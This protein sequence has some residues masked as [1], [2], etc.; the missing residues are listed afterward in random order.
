MDD[1]IQYGKKKLSQYENGGLKEVISGK[2]NILRL[3]VIGT[4]RHCRSN[5]LPNLPFLPV[6]LISV[7]SA[8][9]ANAEYYGKKYGAQ[10]FYD[11]YDDMIEE[12]NL[13]LII[14]PVNSKEHPRMI[15][16]ALKHN[17]PIFVEK[18][19]AE[20]SSEIDNL[21][22]LDQNNRVM[23]GFQKRFAPN[24]IRIKEA[25]RENTYGKLHSLY[26][27]FGV[28]AFGE[29]IEKFFLEVGLHFIDLI[30]YFAPDAQIESVLTNEIKKGQINCNIAFS[31][32]DN[33]I[34]NLHLSSNFDWSNCHERVLAIFEKE[35]IIVNNLVDYS[36][37]A[38]SKTIL[39]I[40][41]EKVSKK[42]IVK[43]NWHPN[44]VSGDVENSSF[45]QTGFLPELRHF[46]HWVLGQQ[47][48]SISN[49]QNAL[50]THQLMDHILN[51]MNK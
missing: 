24:Y 21:L 47:K 44:Y 3:G 19:V 27:E 37:R 15:S 40:P 25:I 39:S 46:S 38:N 26:L 36:S 20:S 18:P 49:L 13:D 42:R 8:H 2:K 34:V 35:N 14:G 51:A 50:G 6:Q 31:T 32:S 33:I 48:N 4:G 22:N 41:M 11:Q 43:E 1:F 16:S 10:S 9:K 23:I 5:L 28:G 7:C 17:I 29:G 45:Q 30:R 12:E